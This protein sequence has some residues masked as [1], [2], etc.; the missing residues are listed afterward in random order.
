MHIFKEIFRLP[1][2]NRM[3]VCYTVVGGM[4]EWTIAAVLKT[5]GLTAPGVRIPLPPFW[6]RRQSDN[7]CGIVVIVSQCL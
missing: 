2:P 1:F 4:A 6:Q 7:A 3:D 5:A